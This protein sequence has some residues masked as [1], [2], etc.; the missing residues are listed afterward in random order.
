MERTV[1][2]AD[3]RERRYINNIIINNNIIISI[4]FKKSLIDLFWWGFLYMEFKNKTIFWCVYFLTAPPSVNGQ[5]TLTVRHAMQEDAGLYECAATNP[6]NDQ[7]TT[8]VARVIIKGK[9]SFNFE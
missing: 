7:R 2:L 1:S 3:A 8:S 9:K 6:A 5:S 4:S